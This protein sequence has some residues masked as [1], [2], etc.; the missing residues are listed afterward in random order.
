M[1]DFFNRLFMSTNA[2]FHLN[3]FVNKTELYRAVSGQGIIGLFFFE[4]GNAESITGKRYRHIVQNLLTA[5]LK[6]MLQM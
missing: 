6:N 3:R 5:A 2:H 4:D 1:N